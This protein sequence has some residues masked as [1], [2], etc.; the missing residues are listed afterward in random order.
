MRVSRQ[1]AQEIGTAIEKAHNIVLITH[2]NPDGDAAGS[3]LAFYEMLRKREKKVTVF[4]VDPWP[5]SFYFLPNNEEVV[6]EFSVQDFD[7]GIILDCG[8]DYMSQIHESHAQ[9]FGGNY[10]LINIDHH[11]SND[12]FGKWNLID[13][14][15]ASTT[16]IL[17]RMFEF[18]D[19]KITP[20]IAT[21]LMTGLYT[22]T[23]SL[24]HSNATA[25]VHRVA[26]KLLRCGARLHD[27]I[28]YVFKNTKPEVLRLWGRILHRI[29]QTAE[30]ITLSYVTD[31]DF[32]ETGTTKADT[33]GVID[34]LN[35][36]PDAKFSLL[37]SQVGEQVKGSMRTL[38]E[39]VDLN[40]IAGK[41]GG[42]GHK[43]AAGFTLA[44]KLQMETRFRIVGEDA[45]YGDEIFQL[46]S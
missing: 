41:L 2:K 27:I 3:A 28:R 36:V 46:S 35:A 34:Y 12:G 26:A 30:G 9:M 6:H 13:T 39:D 16:E 14:E 37:L 19:W 43:K 20:K 15:A 24:K 1:T 5:E 29:S 31:Q 18:L 45:K 40:E 32:R 22:D 21:C 38:Q 44:G 11:P 23:G 33:T 10:P 7:L 8:A 17:T 25:E 42:G 4:C